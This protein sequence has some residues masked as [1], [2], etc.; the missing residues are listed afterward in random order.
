MAASTSVSSALLDGD[1]PIVVP[2]Y[3]PSP[4]SDAGLPMG[5]DPGLQAGFVVLSPLFPAFRFSALLALAMRCLSVF[6]LTNKTSTS[7]PRRATLFH[8][9]FLAGFL[10]I[11]Y[12]LI[13]FLSFYCLFP[14]SSV[15][16]GMAGPLTSAPTWCRSASPSSTLCLTRTSS[17]SV[18]AA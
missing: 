5:L 4:A 7:L 8:L 12:S 15:T 18:C 17:V 11:S 3:S 16:S 14:G 9:V 2:G 13:S 6:V 1:G 10:F